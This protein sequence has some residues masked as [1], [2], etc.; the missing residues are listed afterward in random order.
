MK[1]V[2]TRAFNAMGISAPEAGVII[3]TSAITLAQ[4]KNMGFVELQDQKSK[5]A[6]KK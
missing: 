2:S 6:K 4:L 1:A 5:K 3:E